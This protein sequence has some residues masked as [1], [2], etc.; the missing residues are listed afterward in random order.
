MDIDF[1]K[2]GGRL[3]LYLMKIVKKKIL[4]FGFI[5]V[6]D[7]GTIREDPGMTRTGFSDS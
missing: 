7:N 4:N 6:L 1:S 2:S 3:K 5:P